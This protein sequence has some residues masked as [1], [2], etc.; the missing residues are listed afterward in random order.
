LGS[1]PQGGSQ[2][3]DPILP[4]ITELDPGVGASHGS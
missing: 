3:P 1:R 4:F 2:I